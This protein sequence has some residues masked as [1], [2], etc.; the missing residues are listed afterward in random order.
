MRIAG[1]ID[2]E[3]DSSEGMTE[4]QRRAFV[5]AGLG[6]TNLVN[7]ATARASELE[8][9]ELRRGASRLRG[10]V[11]RQRP[12]VMAVAGV[13]AYREAFGERKAQMGRQPEGLG[14]SELWVVP[15]PSGLNAHET[16]ESLAAWFGRVA[17]VADVL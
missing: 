1:I 5:D 14:S 9:D 6:I 12:R 7:R 13:T 3:I 17:E 10:L 4:S 15:N 8:R 2:W 11:E 16:T